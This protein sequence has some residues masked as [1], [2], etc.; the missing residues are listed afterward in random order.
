[1][2]GTFKWTVAVLMLAITL[3]A[4]VPIVND[5]WYRPVRSIRIAGEFEHVTREVLRAAISESLQAGFYGIDVS[6][7]RRAARRLPWVRDVTVQRIWPD[8]VNITVTERRA[9]ARWNDDALL[10]NDAS[11]FRPTEGTENYI[12]TQLRGP[13]GKHP[14]M[15]EQ[16]KLLATTFGTLAGGIRSLRLSRQGQW[17][18]DFGNGMTLVPGTQLNVTALKAFARVLPRVMGADLKRVERVDLR[19]ANGFAVRWRTPDGPRPEGKQG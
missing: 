19:Y 6:A 16:Y 9:V 3:L 7:V 11:L 1:M 8:S 18:I 2:A 15:L 14:F 12:Y 4:A 5:A 10:E 13:E 17:Q